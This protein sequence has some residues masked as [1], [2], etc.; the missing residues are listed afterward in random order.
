MKHSKFKNGGLLFELLTRQITSDV[1][2]GSASSPSTKIVKQYFKKDTELYKEAKIFNVLQQTKIKNS[3]RA[4]HLIETTI[5]SYN[6][7]VNQSKLRKEKYELIKTIKESFDMDSFFKVRIPN[8]KLLASIYNVLTEDYSDPE[9]SSK[10]YYTVVENI[11]SAKKE[12]NDKTLVELK[13]QNKDLRLLAYQIL[14]EKFNKKYDT[15][16]KDQKKVLREYI[17]SVSSTSTLKTF[18][19]SQFKNVLFELKKYYSSIDN[20]IVKIKI[21]ECV[22]L[23]NETKIAKPKTSHVL[24]LMRFYQLVSEI[25]NVIKK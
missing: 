25:K 20:K 13:R 21:K 14:V 17:N 24:K 15:L 16:S 11:S 12:E 7:T 9:K 18:L 6:K 8:Y 3:D 2:N 5:K 10:S 1:L 19:E 23:V 22:K 4:K